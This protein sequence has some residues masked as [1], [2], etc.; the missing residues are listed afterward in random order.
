MTKQMFELK[1]SEDDDE[2]AYLRLPNHPGA[3]QPG[4]VAS[5]K[6]LADLIDN[7]KGADVYLDFDK[8]GVLIGIEIIS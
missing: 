7:Y 4:V 8:S 5:Q 1:V 2:V 3:G 6:N